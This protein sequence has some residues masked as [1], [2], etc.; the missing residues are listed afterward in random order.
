[1]EILKKI[2]LYAIIFLSVRLINRKI[3]KNV[4][5]SQQLNKDGL[6]YDYKQFARVFKILAIIVAIGV[7]IIS[8][9]P[10][11]T[12]GMGEI[13]VLGIF[14]LLAIFMYF[15]GCRYG[16]WYIKMSDDI[17]EYRDLQ[18]KVKIFPYE[19]ITDVIVTDHGNLEIYVDNKKVLTFPQSMDINTIK[20][21]LRKKGVYREKKSVYMHFIMQGTKANKYTAIVCEIIFLFFMIFSFT[22]A[23]V[24]GGVLF[25]IMALLNTLFLISVFY[26]CYVIENETIIHKRFLKRNVELPYGGI[27]SV[28]RHI[29]DNSDK[30]IY[31]YSAGKV[32]MKIS[33]NS[34]NF[35]LL[36]QLIAKQQWKWRK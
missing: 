35:H 24:P 13:I 36:E 26:N 17:I 3:N 10:S 18:G 4:D 31:V 29:Y 23:Y 28:E 14:I 19:N 30:S 25:G 8:F 6:Y 34:T 1:M 16:N 7:S 5:K 32:V 9:V 22:V 15:C 2:L 11:S 27:D 21:L 33:A 12:A 20:K